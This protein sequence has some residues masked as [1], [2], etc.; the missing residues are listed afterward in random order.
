VILL[1]DGSYRKLKVG[2]KKRDFAMLG[3]TYVNQANGVNK[4]SEIQRAARFARANGYYARVIP[5]AKDRAMSP[6]S[7]G[8]APRW[9]LFVASKPSNSNS[10][11]YPRIENRQSPGPIKINFGGNAGGSIQ[12]IVRDHIIKDRFAGEYRFGPGTPGGKQFNDELFDIKTDDYVRSFEQEGRAL[13]Y[14]ANSGVMIYNRSDP[15]ET[16]VEKYVDE[17]TDD[18]SHGNEYLAFA[19]LKV[20]AE[21]ETGKIPKDMKIVKQKIAEYMDEAATPGL[22]VRQGLPEDS[23]ASL[24]EE[25]LRNDD[26]MGVGYGSTAMLT[27]ELLNALMTNDVM[28]DNRRRVGQE[29]KLAGPNYPEINL[30][31]RAQK[32]YDPTLNMRDNIIQIVGPFGWDQVKK[33]QKINEEFR[34]AQEL[35]GGLLKRSRTRELGSPV[36]ID[37]HGEVYEANI[38]GF[39]LDLKE[40]K[41]YNPRYDQWINWAFDSLNGKTKIVERGRILNTLRRDLLSAKYSSDANQLDTNSIDESVVNYLKEKMFSRKKQGTFMT[42]EPDDSWRK[43]VNLPDPQNPQLANVQGKINWTGDRQ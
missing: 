37:W 2:G 41:D 38:E 6:N 16:I 25:L 26:Q 20:Q 42:K 39:A 35:S 30:W 1:S 28:F 7:F 10:I 29:W 4:A 8:G 13:D 36:E 21:M 23:R 15:E 17:M 12:K 9:G 40:L 43:I 32:K 11:T 18:R 24:T 5:I 22:V 34:K 3:F 33:A 27:D 14:G 19:A 31:L